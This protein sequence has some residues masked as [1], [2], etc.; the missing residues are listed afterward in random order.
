VLRNRAIKQWKEKIMRRILALV[1]VLVAAGLHAAPAA[2][3]SVQ[4]HRISGVVLT[5]ATIA[6]PVVQVDGRGVVSRLG[7]VTT[8]AIQTVTGDPTNPQVGAVIQSDDLVF[9]AADGDELHA[10]YEATITHVRLPRIAFAGTLT[11]TGGTDRFTGASGT[12]VLV[13]G[14]DFQ[15]SRGLF[16]LDGKIA[17]PASTH[18]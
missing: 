14:F 8:T 4:T 7:R 10:T 3:T 9:R 12:A 16:A 11:F 17:L 5:T 18:S 15:T 2:A 1:A 6:P 13:G